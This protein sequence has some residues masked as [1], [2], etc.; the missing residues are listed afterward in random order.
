MASWR[1]G[2][3]RFFGQL[4]AVSELAEIQSVAR[5]VAPDSIYVTVGPI[6][7]LPDAL[8]FIG[9]A[10]GAGP[11][12]ADLGWVQSRSRHLHTEVGLLMLRPNHLE[13]IN[14]RGAF[15]TAPVADVSDLDGHRRSGFV[16]V[17]R[18]GSGLAIG[19]QT[20]V[21]IPPGAHWRTTSGWTNAFSGW[22]AEL[23][24]YGVRTHW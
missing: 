20:P 6:T 8:A 24:R 15:W 16:V 3:T 12:G 19:T 9:G 11:M 13:A 4:G 17:T 23:G 21:E 22:D 1:T 10:P 18:S 2:L 14:E 5:L 7:A